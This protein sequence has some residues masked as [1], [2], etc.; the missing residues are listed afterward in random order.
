M[1]HQQ[2]AGGLT[3]A[4]LL[5]G[6]ANPI[7]GQNCVIKLRDGAAPEDLKF[8]GAPSGIKFALGENV[9]QSNWGAAFKSRFPQTRMGVPAFHANRFTAAQHYAA[10]D[11]EATAR[12]RTA[13]PARSRAR[14]DR[15]D[16]PRR[17]AHP[18]SQLS[19]G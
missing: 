12:G 9:K 5:H 11:R 10:C 16:H 13:C 4:N 18:L 17:A 14:G 2:L 6:S 1:I 15:G 3:V 7:G 19:A 8:P